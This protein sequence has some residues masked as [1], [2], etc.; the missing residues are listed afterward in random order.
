MLALLP[1]AK[2]A[3]DLGMALKGRLVDV[4][5][6]GNDEYRGRYFRGMTRK[7]QEMLFKFLG[8][9]ESLRD[10]CPGRWVTRNNLKS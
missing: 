3:L 9:S 2:E 10:S 1:G 4:R 8:L 7:I 5:W 6:D